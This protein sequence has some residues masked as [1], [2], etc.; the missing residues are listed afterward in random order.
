VVVCVGTFSGLYRTRS[1]SSGGRPGV[2]DWP[3]PQRPVDAVEPKAR[4]RARGG[5]RRPGCPWHPPGTGG[6]PLTHSIPAHA[7]FARGANKGTSE[8]TDQ[9]G[10]TTAGRAA[11]GPLVLGHA[12]VTVR[13]VTGSYGR[14][15]AGGWPADRPR[16]GPGGPPGRNPG[17]GGVF[18]GEALVDSRC[19]SARSPPRD[20]GTRPAHGWGPSSPKVVG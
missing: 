2:V 13:T 4:P 18:E 20:P 12:S 7:P 11:W 15:A 3:P 5:D 16:R 19:S 14:C 8:T 17:P 10:G 6:S 9:G 1:C